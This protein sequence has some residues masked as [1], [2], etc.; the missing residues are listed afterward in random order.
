MNRRLRYLPFSALIMMSSLA[1]TT[2]RRRRFPSGGERGGLSCWLLPIFAACCSLGGCARGAAARWLSLDGPGGAPGQRTSAVALG[3]TSQGRGK[4][5]SCKVGL[6]VF[7][8]VAGNE[9]S[10]T[11][12]ESKRQLCSYPNGNCTGELLLWKVV[13]P[14]S[15]CVVVWWKKLLYL[16]FCTQYGSYIH[17]YKNEIMKPFPHSFMQGMNWFMLLNTVQMSSLKLTL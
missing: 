10:T 13:P 14:Y 15:S 5:C 3:T 7:H 1:P 8:C 6:A 2:A 9:N 17:I 16:A 4:I 11:E 12:S